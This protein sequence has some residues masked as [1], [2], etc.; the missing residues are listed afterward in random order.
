MPIASTLQF[1]WSPSLG[2][3]SVNVRTLTVDRW[4]WKLE[5]FVA[6]TNWHWQASMGSGCCASGRENPGRRR[7]NWTH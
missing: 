1:C 4:A 5:L 6:G 7:T 3:C 2:P